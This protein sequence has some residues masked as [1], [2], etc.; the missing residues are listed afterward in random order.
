[1]DDKFINLESVSFSYKKGKMVFKDFSLSLDRDSISII[2]GENGSGKT[3]LTKLIMGILS[4]QKG[5]V[6]IEGKSNEDLSLGE[7][8]KSIGYLFQNPDHQIF[9]SSV[10]EQLTWSSN[11]VCNDNE[12][13]IEK[14]K[15]LLKEFDIENIKDTYPFYLSMGE[16]RILAIASVMM[17]DVKY[18]I[19]D[20]PTSSLDSKREEV[21]VN[22]IL[23][24]KNK[25]IGAL[26]ITHDYDFAKRIGQRIIH[27]EDGGIKDE[28][29]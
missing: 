15:Y 2:L 18:L 11:L 10:I 13:Y 3:T 27:L 4:P 20:E 17:R 1:M 21:L 9:G 22:M 29:I 7:M 24:L 16:K 26:V 23:N 8:G 14:A 5:K 12:N 6:F 28:L 19:F 25:G